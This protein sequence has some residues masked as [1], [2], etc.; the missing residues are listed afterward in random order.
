MKTTINRYSAGNYKNGETNIVTLQTPSES[1]GVTRIPNRNANNLGAHGT[2]Y[3]A[4]RGTVAEE[5]KTQKSS[6]PLLA[7]GETVFSNYVIRKQITTGLGAEA[8]IYL[9][10]NNGKYY[11]VKAYTYEKEFN[12]RVYNTLKSLNHRNVAR[13]FEY[14]YHSNSKLPVEVIEYFDLGSLEGRK[15]S[16]DELRRIVGQINEGLKALHGKLIY[17]NDLKLQNIVI[18]SSG[19]V[20]I[21]DFSLA[22]IESPHSTTANNGKE[23]G[24]GCGTYTMRNLV[25]TPGYSCPEYYLSGISSRAGDY[26]SLGVTMFELFFGYPPFRN[27]A[28]LGDWINILINRVNIFPSNTPTELEIIRHLIT[29]D[30]HDRCTYN[31]IKKFANGETLTF[32]SN[33]QPIKASFFYTINNEVATDRQSLRNLLVKH[34]GDGTKRLLR[35][36]MYNSFVSAQGGNQD[37]AAICKEITDKYTNR[38]REEGEL[39]LLEFLYRLCPDDKRFVWRGMVFN[40]TEAISNFILS[41]LRNG[42]TDEPTVLISLGVLSVYYNNAIDKTDQSQTFLA[43]ESA[44]K[45]AVENQLSNP[46]DN[47]EPVINPVSVTY[48]Y[49]FVLSQNKKLM[50]K[51][52]LYS[53][54]DI[55]ANIGSFVND[56][57]DREGFPTPE[58]AGF[59]I[60]NGQLAVN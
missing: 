7:I 47:H 40:N 48:A 21:I 41:S 22:S 20:A 32:A 14:G 29:Y 46:Y 16:L 35:G 33:S 37:I 4:G 8:Q 59:L 52:K 34:W 42:N 26:Y 18:N 49:G 30:P 23:F 39:A 28:T 38:R 2:T 54:K 13:L 60:A 24:Q 50:I 10:S 9:A 43:L 27:I 15:L 31:E 51:N 36:D 44:Y 6:E 57:T 45:K 53:E 55:A 3:I 12:D 19:R 58:Y 5:E 17:I 25:G 1:K 11:I 56:L